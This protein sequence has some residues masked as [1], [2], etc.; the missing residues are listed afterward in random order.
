MI[1]LTITHDGRVSTA[2]AEAWFETAS[3]ADITGLARDGWT[4]PR[5]DAVAFD[6]AFLVRGVATAVAPGGFTSSI[7]APAAV[8]W[9]G[10]HRPGL[11]RLL[12]SEGVL[13]AGGH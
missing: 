3:N 1:R 8:A 9:L 4:G 10:E 11:L 13:P 12:R 7:H 2:D 5:A 6:L